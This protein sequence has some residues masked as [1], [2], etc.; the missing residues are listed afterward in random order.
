MPRPAALVD[1]DGTLVDSNYQHALAWWHALR[2]AGR[3]IPIARLHKLIGMGSDQ[4]LETVVGGPDPALEDA[5]GQHFQR[6]RPEVTAL[7]GAAALLQGLSERGF[8]VVLATSGRPDDVEHMRTLLDADRWIDA[9]VSSSEAAA[10]KPAPDIFAVALERAGVPA[11]RAAVIG[12]TAW[13]VE[14]AHRCGLPCVA[15]TTGGWDAC[16]LRS[17]GAVE[18]YDDAAEL[19][20]HLDSGTFGLLTRAAR[21]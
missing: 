16:E 21:S 6:L 4:L 12:D 18:V 8:V 9:E 13:D 19:A 17:R 15:V 20:A 3:T 11:A 7:P 2:D 14:A 1:L 10:T 5:S